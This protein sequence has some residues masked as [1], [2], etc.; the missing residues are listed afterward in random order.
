[1]IRLILLDAI[2]KTDRHLDEYA[3]VYTDKIRDCIIEVR[4]GIAALHDELDSIL[5]EPGVRPT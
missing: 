4:E 2:E 1:M 5:S 3:Y